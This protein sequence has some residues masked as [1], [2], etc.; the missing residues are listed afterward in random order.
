MLRKNTINGKNA[1][2]PKKE[3][4]VSYYGG[5]P[6]NWVQHDKFDPNTRGFRNKNPG[7]LGMRIIKLGY[8]DMEK[9]QW[10]CLLRSRWISCNV[11]TTHA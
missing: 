10:L 11:S 2:A 8:K 9:T 6:D 3:E 7:N 4:P 5:V 1:H